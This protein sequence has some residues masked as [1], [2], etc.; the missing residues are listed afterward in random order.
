MSP[1]VALADGFYPDKADTS[2]KVIMVE[3]V[4]HG[5]TEKVLFGVQTRSRG[6]GQRFSTRGV[7]AFAPPATANCTLVSPPGG[8]VGMPQGQ[9]SGG[10]PALPSWWDRSQK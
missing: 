8:V 5:E 3:E 4:C 2:R 9:D 1:N 6:F 10:L 7:T